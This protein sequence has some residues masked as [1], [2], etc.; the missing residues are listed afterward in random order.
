MAYQSQASLLFTIA[1]SHAEVDVPSCPRWTMLDLAAH[2]GSSPVL[3]GSVLEAAPG[4]R[5]GEVMWPE[6]PENREELLDWCAVELQS[7][8][9][10]FRTTDPAAPAWTG[11]DETGVAAFWMRRAALETAV[12]LWD[13]AAAVG[14]DH[15]ISTDLAADGFDEL[16]ELFPTL[17][18]W[19]GHE[20]RSSLEVAPDD[21]ERTWLYAGADEGEPVA[22]RGHGVDIYLRLWGRRRPDHAAQPA[23]ADWVALI[24][25]LGP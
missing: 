12:H 1:A 19:S 11:A 15:H 10:L 8:V 14:T 21:I 16:A 3:W 20:P 17:Q 22:L 25:S 2:V 4:A 23:V 9:E 6:L 24:E 18:K 5:P 13:A 7:M